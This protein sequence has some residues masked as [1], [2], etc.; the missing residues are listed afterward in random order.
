MKAMFVAA[1]VVA[2]LWLEW[3]MG[4]EINAQ[5]QA[6][7][8]G[9]GSLTAAGTSAG[10]VN[11]SQSL[12]RL[13][14]KRASLQQQV[15]HAKQLMRQ[16]SDG[17]AGGKGWRL[18]RAVL[19]YRA[20]NN[21]WPGVGALQSEAAYREGELWLRLEQPGDAVGAFQVCIDAC[22]T[23]PDGGGQE[24]EFAARARLQLG[25][26]HRRASRFGKAI[27]SYGLVAQQEFATRRHLNDALEWQGRCWMELA[28]WSLAEQAFTRWAAQAENQ[29][30]QVRA[31]DRQAQ[32]LIAA[33]KITKAEVLLS[34][35]QSK[36]RAAS[37][38]PTPE[39]RQLFEA[40][41]RI[42]AEVQ[43]RAV[44]QFGKNH[45]YG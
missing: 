32:A 40:L 3:L 1:V 12:P 30:E 20:V 31:V 29:L 25:H 5:Q 2:F 4:K 33:G 22:Q 21:Y 7:W 45:G 10:P 9:G 18:Q 6:A 43:L 39:A 44:R 13:P 11:S 37:L 35:L 34:E 8:A 17:N 27:H 36:L 41:G 28:Q 16:I 19:A 26:I 38:E 24:L 14:F 23:T 15:D 42:R